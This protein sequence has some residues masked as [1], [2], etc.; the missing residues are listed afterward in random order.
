[1]ELNFIIVELFRLILNLDWIFSILTV[2]YIK[3]CIY[4]VPNVKIYFFKIIN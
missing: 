1:M 2:M 3:Y 4:H